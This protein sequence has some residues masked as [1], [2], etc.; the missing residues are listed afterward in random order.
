MLFAR[1]FLIDQLILRSNTAPASPTVSIILPTF[2]RCAS[3]LLDRAIRSVLAQ[4]F[5]DW[6]LLV[7]DDGSTDGTSE[8]IERFRTADSRIIHVCHE[9]NSG[10]HSLRLNEGIELARGK[11]LAFQFDDD[12]WRPRALQA[13][14]EK[15]MLYTEPVLVTGRSLLII[16]GKERVLPESEPDL[17]RLVQSN[18]IANNN[19]LFPREFANNL[20]MYD[21]HLGMRRLCDWD[22]WLR[23]CQQV[24]IVLV[25]Q[26]TT[27]VNAAQ[28][29]SI[30]LTLPWDL[31]LFRY[32]HEIQRNYLLK[33]DCWRNY[34][35]DALR[36]GEVE[37]AKDFRD[38]LYEEYIVPYYLKHRHH[39]PRIEG[40]SATLPSERKT[41]L[42]VRNGYE[43]THEI[44]FNHYDPISNRRDRYKAYYQQVDQIGSRWQNE[45]D[46]LLLVRSTENEAKDLLAEALVSGKP[47]GYYLDDDLLSFYEY[48]AEFDYLAPG[49]PAHRNVSDLLEGADSVWCNT[50]YLE[51]SVKSKNPRTI[52]HHGCVPAEFLPQKVRPRNPQNPIRIGY[53]GTGYRAEEFETLWTAIQEISREFGNRLIFEF[54]GLNISDRPALASPVFQRAYHP[55][56]LSYL[57]KLQKAGFDI[58]LMP[59]FD[60]PRPRLAKSVSKYF[61]TAVA[62]ALAIFSDVPQYAALPG[63]LTCLKPDNSVES[64]RRALHEAITMPGEKFD[65]MRRRMIEH[66]KE[67]YS[68]T[69]QIHLHEA[70]WRATE[71]HA[72]TRRRRADDGRPRVL[73]VMHSANLGGSEIQLLR[74]VRLA[75]RYGIQPVVVLNRTFQD[76]EKAQRIF[77]ELSA[78]KI[79]IEYAEYTCFTEP[80]SPDEF[81]DNDE[82]AHVYELLKRLSPA[83]VHTLIFNPTFGQVCDELKIPHVA[84]VYA[85][86][87]EFSWPSDRQAFNHCNIVQSDSMRYASQWSNLLG[88]EK[89]CS[90]EPAPEEVFTLGQMR[91]LDSL[92]NS[93]AFQKQTRIVMMGTLQERKRQLEAL[94]AFGN[95]VLE[96]WDCY[97][98]VYGY[99]HFNPEYAASCKKRTRDLDIE[100]RV[101]FYDFTDDVVSI[102]KSADLLFSP[103]TWESFP[104]SIKEA[105]AGGVLVVATPA[106][107][108]PELILDETTGILCKDASVA[109]LTDGL[110]RAL[111]M[112]SGE[113]RQIIERARRVARSEF[114]P[115]RIASDL[116][117][118]Y[119]RAIELN[120]APTT[121]E[122]LTI[123]LLNKR[124][125]VE[126]PA[127]RPAGDAVL[128]RSLTYSFA[129]KHNHWNG[130]SVFIGT[131]QRPAKGMLRLQ[132][133][134][135]SGAQLRESAQSIK[136]IMDN[137]W[138]ELRFPPIPDAAGKPFRLRFSLAG[139]D[140]AT[141]VSLYELE[142][143]Q[144]KILRLLR[145]MGIPF[146]NRTLYCKSW[147]QE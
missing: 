52:P 39:F 54:W 16:D 56:Y 68:E 40:F 64:W 1:D 137:S 25:D 67:E 110:R 147:Y 134:S 105:M 48:G 65:L 145:H 4:S 13:L 143:A 146:K 111:A 6:E 131:H 51:L 53:V 46:L 123:P 97:L 90:R 124:G 76:S 114:H 66:V 17:R 71:F 73:Y 32:L 3:G 126:S 116:F 85:I 70:A 21:C 47:V 50:L 91:Y 59:L 133:L 140:S 141:K 44:A 18:Q 42:Y 10:I 2:A 118:M 37:V 121:G 102:L 89:F 112:E 34:E 49:S 82:R 62:G 87:D 63:G 129:P 69:A 38:R 117:G 128:R 103:S 125:R 60:H 83:L 12:F 86:D 26:I 81:R 27:E 5:T 138:V 36:I 96:G 109:S 30:G 72:L 106:G 74:R 58:M 95:L 99:Q 43:P 61:Q 92:D 98:N 15:A 28:S 132:V 77:Q 139:A 75:Y 11:F 31:A 122:K 8:L 80:H 107:G 113:R 45:T 115:Q 130:V 23:Y 20:G 9:R 136:K 35:I 78:E 135:Q 79:E 88:A 93:F 29:G 101:A 19:V 94:Q 127:R 33:P 7:I 104:N 142:P 120:G 84:S 100:N 22:L 144:P 119:N 108:I 41:A 57:A 24:P 55:S 14:V